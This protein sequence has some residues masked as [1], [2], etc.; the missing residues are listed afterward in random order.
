MKYDSNVRN[1]QFEKN[2]FQVADCDIALFEDSRIKCQEVA[3]PVMNDSVI[4]VRVATGNPFFLSCNC[5]T[6]KLVSC[7]G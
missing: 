5:S 7:R 1:A 6:R 4:N 2:N 3:P